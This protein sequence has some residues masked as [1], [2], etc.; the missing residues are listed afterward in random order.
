[1]KAILLPIAVLVCMVRV[2]GRVIEDDYEKND[3]EHFK[4]DVINK[5]E[6]AVDD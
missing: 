3:P 2:D 4:D 1:M 6:G 5:A